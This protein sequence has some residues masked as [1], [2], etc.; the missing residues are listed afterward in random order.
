MPS[1][2]P[3]PDHPYP[4]VHMQGHVVCVELV[5]VSHEHPIMVLELQVVPRPLIIDRT[6]R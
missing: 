1:S 3:V 2:C 5:S 4:L 6:F